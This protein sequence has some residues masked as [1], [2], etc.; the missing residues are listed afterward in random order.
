VAGQVEKSSA[1]HERTH[2]NDNGKPASVLSFEIVLAHELGHFLGMAHSEL[3]E[4]IMYP[5][6][7][8]GAV[9]HVQLSEDDIDGVETLYL[10]LED[11][12]AT[13]EGIVSGCQA[14]PGHASGGSWFLLLLLLGLLFSVRKLSWQTIRVR[15]LFPDFRRRPRPRDIG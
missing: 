10:G 4:A 15:T 1:P 9:S 13:Q 5:T 8:T 12:L 3:D 6:T 11:K 2:S 14:A 7:K